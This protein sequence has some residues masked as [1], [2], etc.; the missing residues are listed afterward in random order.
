V[1]AH[2][3][4]AGDALAA[5]IE[6]DVAADEMNRNVFAPGMRDGIASPV[7]KLVEQNQEPALAG[8]CRPEISLGKL[9][10]RLGEGGPGADEAVPRSARSPR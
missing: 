2:R 5:A 4:G 10:P 3:G 9:L 6:R 1:R 8:D 7:A